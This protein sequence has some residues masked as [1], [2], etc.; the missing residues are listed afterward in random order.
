MLMSCNKMFDFS[1]TVITP[2][3]DKMKKKKKTMPP[4]TTKHNILAFKIT[5]YNICSVTN[6]IQFPHDNQPPFFSTLDYSDS[7]GLHNRTQ[8]LGHILSLCTRRSIPTPRI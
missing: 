5:F 8:V 7:P 6:F 3:I 2:I 1:L 4:S